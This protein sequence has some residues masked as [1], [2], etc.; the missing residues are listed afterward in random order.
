MFSRRPPGWLRTLSAE[1]VSGGNDAPIQ[2][3][4]T[5]EGAES[6]TGKDFN[7]LAIA[8]QMAGSNWHIGT[9]LVISAVVYSIIL[10]FM[11]IVNNNINCD[12]VFIAS[13]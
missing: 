9:R 7:D 4:L 5:K 1:P 2:A 3:Q 11:E 10:D 8:V 12:T 6:M 13:R